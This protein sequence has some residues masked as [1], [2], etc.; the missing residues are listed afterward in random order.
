MRVTAIHLTDPGCPWA[1]S[2]RPYHARLRWRFGDQLAWRL[3]LIGLA[4]A[5]E[6]YEARGYTPELAVALNR[7]FEQRFG[8]PFVHVPKDRVAATSP[9]CRAIVAAREQDPSLAEAALRA[10]QFQHFTSD[11][12]L[13]DRAAL[14]ATL[15]TVDGLDADAILA[16]LEDPAVLAAYEADRALARSAAGTP[17][18]VQ[19]RC[20]RTDGPVRYTA[21]SVVFE[22]PDGRRFEVGG[23]QPFESYDTALANLE[24][25]LD[26]RAEP[27][28]PLE[29]LGAFREGLTTAE[30]AE[31][32]R[33]DLGP[34]DLGGTRAALERLAA[35]GAVRGEPLAGDALW[36]ATADA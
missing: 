5:P 17:S 3:V 35:E 12:R 15:A 16:R 2:A 36:R 29:A 30:L 1:Y 18:D 28:H 4:E 8:M 26:R 23:F 32:L 34:R 11:R 20:A 6:Q 22:H 31:V 7:L 13:D 10:L 21:P 9:A 25:G 27:A 14:R 33:S 24:P 19:G